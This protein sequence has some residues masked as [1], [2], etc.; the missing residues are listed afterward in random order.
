MNPNTITLRFEQ[1]ADQK[2]AFIRRLVGFVKAKYLVDL[3]DAADLSA[4][5]RSAKVGIVTDDI[6]ESITKTKELFPFKTKGILLAVSTPPEELERQRYKL[7]FENSDIEGILDGGHNTL[8]VA[9]HILKEATSN[10]RSISRIKRWSDLKQ[11]WSE[12]KSKIETIRAS[13]DFLVPVEILVPVSDDEATIEKFKKSIL[14]ICSARNNNVQLIIDTKANQA[15][16]FEIIKNTIDPK[17]RDQVIWKTNEPGRIE[18]RDLIALAWLPLLCVEL[19]EGINKISPYQLYSSKGKCM[20]TFID[21]MED[22]NI[23]K[24]ISGRYE[25]KNPLIGSALGMLKDL[26]RIYDKIYKMFPESY[27]KSDGRFG[28]IGSVKIYDSFSLAE[29]N[30]D[31]YLKK[32]PITPFYGEKIKYQYAD[33][34][35]APLIYGLTA[36]IKQKNKQDVVWSVD[37]DQFIDDNLDEIVGG[38]K[39]I[40][41]MCNWDPVKMGKN[42]GSYQIARQQFENCLLRQKQSKKAG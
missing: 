42:A 29:E 9:I 22:Q 24:Q 13:L 32:Q 41:D 7:Q 15:G 34:F 16:H 17:I 12:Y 28:K 23:S 18:V 40:V 19:P 39:G 14:D 35:V 38:Y 6:I 1:V 5:P 27:N 31:K 2:N 11:Y 33:G 3:I 8:A 30:P 21:L 20:K 10:D 37:P 25:L 36:L 4:N 26:P